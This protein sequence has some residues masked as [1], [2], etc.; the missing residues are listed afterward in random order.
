M[1]DQ[2]NI[3]APEFDSHAMRDDFLTIAASLLDSTTFGGQISLAGA[4]LA[5]HMLKLQPDSTGSPSATTA[6]PVTSKKAGGLAE[7]YASLYSATSASDAWLM[8][9]TYGQHFLYIRRGRARVAPFV[10][11][12]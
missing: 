7:S 9:T 1:P 11:M 2:L 4:Y 6:G 10:A 8:R 3:V 5:A 12:P